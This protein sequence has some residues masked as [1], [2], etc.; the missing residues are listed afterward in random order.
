MIAQ[1]ELA[2]LQDIVGPRWVSTEPCMM[3]TYSFYMNPETLVKD[4][5]RWTPRPVAVVLPETTEQVSEI[6]RLFGEDDMVLIR[7][8]VGGDKDG[9]PGVGPE[10]TDASL[11]LSRERLLNFVDERLWPRVARDARLLADREL[12]SRFAELQAGLE[13]LRRVTLADGGRL[14]SFRESLEAFAALYASAAG[15]ETTS[16]DASSSLGGFS[17]IWAGGPSRP[18]SCH[19]FSS[20]SRTT[21]ASTPPWAPSR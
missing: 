21:R 14:T 15:S 13:P 16:G 1:D 9:H 17:G 5:G 4:G 18:S 19:G 11:N 12:S 3:D 2:A 6:L 7:T 10:Q 8:W 20:T